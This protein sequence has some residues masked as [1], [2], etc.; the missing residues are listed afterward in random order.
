MLHVNY[1]VFFQAGSDRMWFIHAMYTIGSNSRSRRNILY[2]SKVSSASQASINRDN[3]DARS[4]SISSR[5]KRGIF[6][7]YEEPDAGNNMVHIDFRKT[8]VQDLSSADLEMTLGGP[9]T[10][11]TFLLVLILGI[12]LLICVFVIILAIFIRHRR[13]HSSPPPTPTNTMTTCVSKVGRR[14][15]VHVKQNGHS[16]HM[17][18]DRTEV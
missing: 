10:F 9:M 8:P 16:G 4:F 12:C 17:T 2:H 7:P 5:S 13:K 14:V 18:Q 11:T 3:S 1:S 15:V 6:T